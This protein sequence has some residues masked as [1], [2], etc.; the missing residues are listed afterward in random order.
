MALLVGI[1]GVTVLVSHAINLG[2]VP[3]DRTGALA[4]LVASISWSIASA[5]TRKLKLPPSKAMSSGAQ[6][7]VGGVLLLVVAALF[8]EFRDFHVQNVSRG[9]WF[10]L[11]YLIVGGSIAGFTAYLWLLHHE[12]ATKVATYAYVNPVVAVA[13]GYFFGGEALGTRTLIGTALVLVSVIVIV[14]TPKRKSATEWKS[15]PQEV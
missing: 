6:M 3:I 4:L 2:E 15:E 10:A 9:A 8:G 7:L 12:S 1:A 5:L 11:A 14:T 13:I